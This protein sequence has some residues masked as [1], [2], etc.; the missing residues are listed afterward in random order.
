MDF[1][2][3]KDSQDR[4]VTVG[5]NVHS[6]EPLDTCTRYERK[7][8]TYVNVERPNLVR[9]YNERISGVDKADMLLSFYRNDLKTKKW[10][11]RVLFHLIDLSVTNAWLLYR[12]AKSAGL[13]LADFKLQVA[14]GLMHSQESMPACNE[15]CVEPTLAKAGSSTRA[16]EGSTSKSGVV[17]KRAHHVQSSVRYDSFAHWPVK[18]AQKNAPMC[19]LDACTRRTRFFCK[20]CLVYLCID[21]DGINC[22]EKFHCALGWSEL[23]TNY[24]FL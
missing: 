12:K 9:V 4:S 1:R 22:F 6:V 2:T 5:S 17:S 10:Y 23:V 19:K 7:T 20:E 21:Q 16:T 3:E 15:D 8:K 18:V 11:K 13:H 14:L 24:C